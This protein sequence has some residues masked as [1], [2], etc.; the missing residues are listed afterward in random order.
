MLIKVRF[1]KSG[2]PRGGEYTYYANDNISVGDKV[3]L[4]N[5][6]GIVVLTNVPEEEVAA[7]RDKIKAITGK[8][9]ESNDN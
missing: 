1:L 2:Q 5:G 3:K 9:E 7:F 8:M 6:E 4:P